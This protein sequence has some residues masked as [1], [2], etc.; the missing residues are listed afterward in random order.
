M[1]SKMWIY[2][3]QKCPKLCTVKPEFIVQK[4]SRISILIIMYSKINVYRNQSYT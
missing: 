4:K 1:Y 3:K 2:R